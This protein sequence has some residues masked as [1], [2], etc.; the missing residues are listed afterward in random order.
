MKNE[1]LGKKETVLEVL[2]N[3]QPIHI[4][5]NKKECF[6]KNAKSVTMQSLHKEII[7]EVNQPFHQKPGIEMRLY[8]NKQ[9]QFGPK[10]T[11]M[12]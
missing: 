9:C 4:S 3:S 6:G 1:L 10:T 11:E 2:G 5:K 8:Q 7:H 12:G